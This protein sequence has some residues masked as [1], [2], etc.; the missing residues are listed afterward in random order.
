VTAELEQRDLV[1][2]GAGAAGSWAAWRAAALGVADVLLLEKTPR[3]GTKVLASGGT[4]CNLTTTLGPDEAGRLFGPAGARFLRRALRGLPPAE[5][6]R[7]FAELGV[8]TEEAPLE[9]I[10]PSSGSAREVRDALRAAVLAAGVELRTDS[11]VEAVVERPQEGGPWGPGE[12]GAR[13][14]LSLAGGR[15]VAARRLV[16]AA[17]GRSY[18][19]TGTTGDGYPWLR[20]LG[21][22]LTPTVPALVP[23]A[24][25][26][27]WVHDLAGIALQAADCRLLDEGGKLLGRRQRPLLFTHAGLS[28]PG[29]MDLSG[30]VAR[31][32]DRRGGRL[33]WILR[34]DPFPAIEREQLRDMLVAGAGRGGA[35]RLLRVVVDGLA[36]LCAP[37][38]LEPPPKR[39]L[40]A[41]FAQAG[42]REDAGHQAL[43]KPQ[44]HALVEA[45]KGL[46]I[47]I[48]GTLGFDKAEVTTGGLA[49]SQVDPGSCRVRGHAGLWVIGELLDLDG[50]I[51]GLNFQSAFATAELCA[52]DLAK[53]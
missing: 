16:L 46:D 23:L 20:G 32:V 50:P 38:G 49:L 6:R 27:T 53:A 17:G 21:L 34:V 42:V 15:R 4:R 13:F 33:D 48:G 44:R 30:H 52:R 11:P 10:F 2:V 1:V 18:P 31:E 41:A 9:K 22:E 26:A 14:E 29:P 45:L 25:P 40:L 5:V 47:P 36:E 8:A 37:L 24:S 7:R 28:G 12:A 35:P 39:V 19:G 51:G 3:L 43:G